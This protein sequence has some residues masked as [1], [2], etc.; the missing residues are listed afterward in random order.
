M[1]AHWNHAGRIGPAHYHGH[2]FAG[3][4]AVAEQHQAAVFAFAQRHTRLADAQ[5]VVLAR[6]R[7]AFHVRDID[8]EHIDRHRAGLQRRDEQCGQQLRAL[9]KL[10]G[11]KAHRISAGGQR[12]GA[13]QRAAPAISIPV[14]PQF[15]HLIGCKARG[16]REQQHLIGLA[17]HLERRGTRASH[18]QLGARLAQYVI[19]EGGIRGF[20]RHHQAPALGITHGNA[21][22]ASQLA[23]GA[24]HGDERGFALRRHL[25]A[26][27][28]L[29]S[30][31]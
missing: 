11:G 19:D 2:M 26:W 7:M 16:Q 20:Q 12:H 6:L 8:R 25:R 13:A 14:V 17:G 27:H 28:S 23:Q 9:G 3:I 31:F 15:T 30:G 5:Q 1:R 22:S 24:I 18:H 21:P 29:Q 4:A 10:H